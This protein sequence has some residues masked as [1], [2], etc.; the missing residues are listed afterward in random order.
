MYV[1]NDQ[2][3]NS[4]LTQSGRQKKT[5]QADDNANQKPLILPVKGKKPTQPASPED[6]EFE[7]KVTP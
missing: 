2:S 7:Q 6:D 1:S 3:S 5:S 4:K